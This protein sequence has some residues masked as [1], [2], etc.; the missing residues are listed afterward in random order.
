MKRRK[1]DK[2]KNKK[3][4]GERERER[5]NSTDV[6]Q[7]S[8]DGPNA[9]K[10]STSKHELNERLTEFIGWHEKGKHIDE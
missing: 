6:T 7:V 8:P 5:R 4:K 9:C 3:K 1:T 2:K 10:Q